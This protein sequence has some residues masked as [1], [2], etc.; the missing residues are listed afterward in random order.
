MDL[1]IHVV[2]RRW[3]RSTAPTRRRALAR[4]RRLLGCRLAAAVGR[5]PHRIGDENGGR[6]PTLRDIEDIVGIIGG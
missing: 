3:R 5:S 4:L 1:L 6:L 2:I